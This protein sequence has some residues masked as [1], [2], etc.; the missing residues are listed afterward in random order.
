MSE[1]KNFALIGAAGYIAPRH[2]KAIKDVGH[3]LSCAFDPN[4]SV[5]VLDRYFFDVAYFKE[6]ERF[7]RHIEKLRY[8]DESKKIDYVSICSPNH[9]H[10]AHIRFGL[11]IG[12]DVICEK[13][14]VI[15]PWNIDYL[16]EIES[17]SSG[18]VYTVLQLRSHESIINLKKKIDEGPKDKVYDIDLVYLTSR[19]PWYHYSWKGDEAKS[20]G[21]ATNIGVHFFDMLTWIFGSVVKSEVHVKE[22]DVIGGYLEL[23]RG[24]VKWI[25]SV[26]RDYLPKEVLEKGQTTYRSIK[27]DGEEIEFSQGFTDLHTVVYKEILEGK[28]YGLD[29]AREAIKIVHDIRTGEITGLGGNSH[30]LLKEI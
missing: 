3:H 22:N 5:G 24:R 18:N 14:L 16:K 17:R 11:R 23:E 20:G 9:L 27:I 15:N 2:L 7:D 26:N 13:P 25:L 28:G 6:F 29:A 19:G 1:V 8:E 10:D 21:L 4:D 12:A 30:Q